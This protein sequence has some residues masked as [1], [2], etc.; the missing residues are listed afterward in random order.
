MIGLCVG[1]LQGRSYTGLG[2]AF[3]GVF[4]SLEPTAQ[5]SGL[6]NAPCSIDEAI[7]TSTPHVI[8]KFN[9]AD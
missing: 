6:P 8:E 2:R 3:R 9:R 7:N 5:S 4:S 1:G